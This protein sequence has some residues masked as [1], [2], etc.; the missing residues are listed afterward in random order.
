[1]NE[2]LKAELEDLRH[3]ADPFEEFTSSLGPDG[4]TVSLVRRGEKIALRRER[5]A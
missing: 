3:F 5:P 2:V 1:M 4:W